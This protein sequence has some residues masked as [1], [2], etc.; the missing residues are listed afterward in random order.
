MD[1]KPTTMESFF[2]KYKI[3]RMCDTKINLT[4]GAVI[5]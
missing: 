5:T 3:N 2:K 1:S 4:F